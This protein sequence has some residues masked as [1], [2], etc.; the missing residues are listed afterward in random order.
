MN[1]FPSSARLLFISNRMCNLP[2]M[3]SLFNFF[4]RPTILLALISSQILI[5]FVPPPM[6]IPFYPFTYRLCAML[7]LNL[8]LLVSLATLFNTFV[9]ASPSV[10]YSLQFS[11]SLFLHSVSIIGLFIAIVVSCITVHACVGFHKASLSAFLRSTQR[12]FV[13]L[14][15]QL[16]CCLKLAYTKEGGTLSI[17]LYMGQFT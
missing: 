4:V 15:L 13:P 16:T 11:C 3:K 17:Q 12:Y 7:S 10:C 6:V 9:S 8:Y 5:Y 1:L 14:S 2:G